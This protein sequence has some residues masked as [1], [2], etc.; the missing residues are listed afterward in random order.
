VIIREIC[1]QRVGQGRCELVV[2][3][4]SEK[5]SIPT[6]PAL[7]SSD[8]RRTHACVFVWAYLKIDFAKRLNILK[9]G[10][11]NLE[12]SPGGDV[13]YVRS[14]RNA[15]CQQGFGR[16]LHS[17]VV[18]EHYRINCTR[19]F[20]ISHYFAELDQMHVALTLVAECLQRASQPD[21]RWRLPSDHHTVP[22]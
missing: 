16:L 11:I 8:C 1:P 17:Q 2:C 14:L 19:D 15:A 12:E 7:E 5:F 13:S 6:Y 22:V 10:Q 3:V 4:A 18:F 21:R 9:R 20:S